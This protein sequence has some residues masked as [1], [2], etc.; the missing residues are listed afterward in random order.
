MNKVLLSTTHHWVHFVK[1]NKGISAVGLAYF[2]GVTTSFISRTYADGKEELMK[3]RKENSHIK[4]KHKYNE[5]LRACK[6]GCVGN[7]G[8][9]LW[10]SIIVPLTFISDIVPYIILRLNPGPK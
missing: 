6:R 9:N 1:E 4:S 7:I 3:Y 5:E 10:C 2:T 8:C